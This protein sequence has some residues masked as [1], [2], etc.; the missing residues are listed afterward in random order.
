MPTH[1]L[2]KIYLVKIANCLLIQKFER[3]KKPVTH[4]WCET[5][6][7]DVWKLSDLVDE[8][9]NKMTILGEFI[10]IY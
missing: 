7:S 5:F 9:Q 8:N 10:G 3:V 1:Q 6:S 4:I 2:Q